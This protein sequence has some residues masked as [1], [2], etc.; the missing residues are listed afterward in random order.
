MTKHISKLFSPPR[1]NTTDTVI[2]LRNSDGVSLPCAWDGTMS[3][4]KGVAGKN[5]RFATNFKLY[6]GYYRTLIGNHM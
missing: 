5:S 3:V 1:I 4:N 2:S 6:L